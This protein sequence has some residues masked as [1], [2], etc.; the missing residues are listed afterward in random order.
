MLR[1][2]LAHWR[3]KLLL[4]IVFNA[5]FWAGYEVLGRHAF[6]PPQSIPLTGLDHAIPFQPSPW[7]WVYLSQFSFTS[8]L[9]WFLPTREEILRCTAGLGV[10]SLLCFA[11]FFFYPVPPPSRPVSPDQPLS[12]AIIAAYDGLYTCFPSLHAAFL[13]Y[14]GALAWR[15]YRRAF[16]PAGWV[17]CGLWGLGILYSTIATRQHYAWDLAAGL[18]VGGFSFWLAWAG[19]DSPRATMRRS[20]SAASQGG[21]R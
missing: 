1:A 16:R 8:L 21:S 13:L 19:W 2:F 20:S 6:F 17:L 9:P 4:T 14:M 10:M 11:V 5:C 12:M 18:A 7:G 15:L 3:L